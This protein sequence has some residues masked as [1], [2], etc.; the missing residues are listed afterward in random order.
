[1]MIDMP[2]LRQNMVTKDW[3]IIATERA[4]RPEAFRVDQ[5]PTPDREPPFDPNCP[6]CP[7][8]EFMSE[9]VMRDH[10]ESGDGWLLRVV[11][12]KFPALTPEGERERVFD[13]IHRSLSG[14]GYHEVLIETPVHN[15]CPA[16][17][18]EA[19]VI[20]TMFAFQRRGQALKTDE[21]IEHLIYFKNHG[22][23]AGS[24]LPHPHA[25]LVALPVVPHTIR[26]RNDEAR[27]H[28]DDYGTCVMCEMLAGELAAGD[29]IVF[30]SEHF[31]ALIPYA[32]YSPFHIWV[33]PRAHRSSFLTVPEEAV[34]DLGRIMRKVLRKL[35]FGLGD[36]D[37]NYVIRTSP[38]LDELSPHQ[39]WYVAVVPRVS[40][41][42]G[43]EL[44]SGMFINSALPETSAEFL[45]NVSCEDDSAPPLSM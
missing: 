24:S 18:T 5:K 20:R 34:E 7:G 30:E 2:E 21:R 36:P 10:A 4:R 15:S 8:N 29:R 42:A 3:V 22:V 41:S 26:S 13:G 28:F 6:F 33:V 38:L 14:I 40:Q 9:E 17:E 43:F 35:Y 16:L 31:V 1:M 45:R 11:N 27:R 32:A 37:Y 12:N 44:G 23:K 19:E 39:H 25:Q